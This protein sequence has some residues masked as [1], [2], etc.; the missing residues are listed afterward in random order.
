MKTKEKD[1][2]LGCGTCNYQYSYEDWWNEDC[3]CPKEPKRPKDTFFF[4]GDE[5][6]TDKYYINEIIGIE[7]FTY[8][9]WIGG[10]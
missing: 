3:N 6:V 1:N 7:E 8:D 2:V 10:K 5:G 4:S 9:N